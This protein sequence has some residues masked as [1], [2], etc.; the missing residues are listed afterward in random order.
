M[1]PI[2]Q[3][4]RRMLAWT[5]AWTPFAAILI[6]VTRTLARLTLGESA[7]TMGPA[8]LVLALVCLSPFYMC[9]ALPLRSSKPA[10]LLL[11]HLAAALVLS[12]CVMLTGRFFAS[13]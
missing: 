7:I 11:N 1:H 2:L 12:G 13:L 5:A 10:R 8:V 3:D 9:R 6:L 4:W